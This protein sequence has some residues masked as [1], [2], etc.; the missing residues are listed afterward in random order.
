MG[1]RGHVGQR[2]QSD[3][4]RTT[5]AGAADVETDHGLGGVM[6]GAVGDGPG[7]AVRFPLTGPTSRPT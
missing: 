3:L 4:I 5:G 6:L 7:V 1:E 2:Q